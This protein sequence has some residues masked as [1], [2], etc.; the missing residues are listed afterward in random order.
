MGLI[1]LD[2]CLIVYAVEEHPAYA[3]RVRA[4]MLDG[5][6]RLA[7]SD[8]VRLECLV[9]PE[10][11]GDL[12]LVERYSRVLDDLISLNLTSEVYARA[13]LLRARF[14]LRTPDALHLACAQHHDCEAVWTNDNRLAAAAHGLARN[15]IVAPSTP[16]WP[17]R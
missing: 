9:G 12:A 13:T 2:T 4:A 16:H 14:G 8:L 3:D 15:I 11:R 10:R 7:I 17:V 5:A 6:G 1:Y